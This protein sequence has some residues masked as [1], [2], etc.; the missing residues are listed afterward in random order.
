MKFTKVLLTI[1]LCSSFALGTEQI[2]INMDEVASYT[3]Q[4]YRVNLDSQTEQGKTQ[5]I[6]E[7]T[8]TSQIADALS[9]TM[10]DDVDLKVVTKLFTVDI[11]A[12]KFMSTI[13]PSDFELKNIFEVQ[14]PQSSSKYNLR[15]ILVKDESTADK[16]MKQISQI[17]DIA[18]QTEK[19]KELVKSESIDPSAKTTEGAIGFIETNK[20]DKNMQDL[21]NGKKAGNIV[22]INI[23]QIG[24][25]ILFI[26]EFQEAKLAT[27]EESKPF[28]IG[29]VRQEALKKEINRLLSQQNNIIK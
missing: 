12:K 3:V 11:W 24:W 22:K 19:F 26:E 5:L 10:K 8:Q 23:P 6:N 7:Y 16:L 20:L 21:L 25:Q 9:K 13:N 17:K 27:F 28:L 2:K 29:T 18:K 4:K 15:T 14:K 1:S